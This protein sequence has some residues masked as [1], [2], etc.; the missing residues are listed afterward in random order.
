MPQLVRPLRFDLR[1]G[2]GRGGRGQ[3]ERSHEETT[4]LL[5]AG[6]DLA[7]LNLRP[8]AVPLGSSIYR[9]NTE[10]EDERGLARLPRV[11]CDLRCWL[12]LLCLATLLGT[13]AV[14]VYTVVEH[15]VTRHSPPPPPWAPPP[16]LPLVLGSAKGRAAPLPRIG[17]RTKPPPPRP[18]PPSPAA[19]VVL[20]T[21]VQ[22]VHASPPP[23][24]L[25]PPPPSPSPPAVTTTHEAG[26]GTLHVSKKHHGSG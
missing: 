11:P 15:A 26:S 16:P 5:G 23:P 4:A 22:L 24:P 7:R 14:V 19:V 20:A 10:E 21:A 8:A 25:P 17:R 12:V 6:T 1:M 13:A 18:P 9:A 3:N 2:R